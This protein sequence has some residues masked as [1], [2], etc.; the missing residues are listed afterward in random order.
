[1][2]FDQTR[3]NNI[4]NNLKNNPKKISNNDL[5]YYLK[6]NSNNEH[7]DDINLKKS[8]EYFKK[9]NNSFIFENIFVNN[10]NY[11]SILPSIIGLLLPFYYFYPRFYKIGFIGCF[12][13]FVCLLGIYSKLVNL[14]SN[15]FKNIG[16]SFLGLSL[17]IYIVFF[18]ALNKLNHISLFFI[19][20]VISYLII[21]SSSDIS[22]SFDTS[23]FL[24]RII[25]I[26]LF[27]TLY[28]LIFS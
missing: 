4:E 9:I 14:Y 12:I 27:L 26:T 18:I 22:N 10:S 21:N 13:G 6:C 17:V 2:G 24:S 5:I 3:I 16:T 7:L 19:S 11:A 23:Y 25:S 8:E 28:R 1:M 15:F 20:A